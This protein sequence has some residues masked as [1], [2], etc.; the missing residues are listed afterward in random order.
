MFD[1]KIRWR[2]VLLWGSLTLA[3]ITL[4]AAVDLARP[5]DERTHLGRLVESVSDEG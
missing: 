2:N 1:H 4:F 3:A 5:S